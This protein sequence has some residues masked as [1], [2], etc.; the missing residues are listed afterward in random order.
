MPLTEER[1]T[2]R[3]TGDRYSGPIAA[4]TILYAGALVCRNAAGDLVPGA[5]A[6][7]LKPMGIAA[8]TFD[9]SAGLAGDL[10]GTYEKGIFPFKNSAAADEITKAD[11][12]NTAYIVDDE[13]V[14][15]TNGT[16]TRSA[17]G[18]IMDVDSFGVWID[19]RG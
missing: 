14:A 7:T 6:T 4:E 19:L 17:A 9:N 11:I 1:A 12:G 3:R 18:K 10:K 13:T 15:K 16:N 8:D 2:Q 5:V